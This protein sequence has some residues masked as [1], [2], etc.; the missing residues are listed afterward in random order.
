M[1]WVIAPDNAATNHTGHDSCLASQPPLKLRHG[2]T[3]NHTQKPCN[4]LSTS[5]SNLVYVNNRI[6]MHFQNRSDI[7]SEET[8]VF[9]AAESSCVGGLR[10]CRTFSFSAHFPNWKQQN[11]KDKTLQALYIYIYIK[12]MYIHFRPY[13]SYHWLFRFHVWE[14]YWSQISRC[15]MC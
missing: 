5:Q 4:Y 12:H 13:I 14:I 3:L 9:H 10:S 11:D 2:W 6:F 15:V 1:S 8:I 7:C